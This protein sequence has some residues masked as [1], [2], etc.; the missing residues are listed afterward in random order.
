MRNV[1]ALA[2]AALAGSELIIAQLVYMQFPSSVIALNSTNYDV[3]FGGVTYRAAAGLGAIA[4]IEDSPGEIKGIQLQMSG[5][6][7]EYLALALADA[8]VVQGA[9]LV[10]RLAII[11]D[12]GVVLDAPLDWIGTV[13]TMP[14]EEDGETCSVSLTA[15]SSAV[16]LLRGNAL[17]TSDPD[18]RFLFPGDLAFQYVVPQ[19][20]EQV[21][22]P[23]KQYY[24][25]SR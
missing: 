17:T 24:I 11:S 5:V 25:D 9:T 14:I 7:T 10:I 22:W 16:D 13:D 8:T 19:A 2:L 12:A 4:E 20:D 3:D 21:V 15:E 23:T 1:T 6:P 18:Q